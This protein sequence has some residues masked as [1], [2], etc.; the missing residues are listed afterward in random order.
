[1]FDCRPLIGL[2]WILKCDTVSCLSCCLIF[3]RGGLS[4]RPVVFLSCSKQSFH[5]YIFFLPHSWKHMTQIHISPGG[6]RGLGKA[7]SMKETWRPRSTCHTQLLPQTNKIGNLSLSRC[8]GF[9]SIAKKHSFTT[10]EMQT[11]WIQQ[12][13]R[14]VSEA[15]V[16]LALAQL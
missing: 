14:N 13:K 15:D 9:R 2:C 6:A 4:S 7:E 5:I 1:M 10:Y 3:L 8:A 16:S 11:I 12:D